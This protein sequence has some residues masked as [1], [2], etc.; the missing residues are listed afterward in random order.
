MNQYP[1]SRILA[2]RQTRSYDRRK[3]AVTMLQRQ[4]AATSL[5]LIVAPLVAKAPIR[6]N[7]DVA[8]CHEE[9]A[10]KHADDMQLRHAIKLPEIKA[11]LCL[12]HRARGQPI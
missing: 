12:D 2:I 7:C 4:F 8:V 10:G 11:A 6:R 9:I 3:L 5:L 1:G